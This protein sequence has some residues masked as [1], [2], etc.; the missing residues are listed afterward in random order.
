MAHCER[1]LR[2]PRALLSSR[3][4]LKAALEYSQLSVTATT[5]MR[6]K[7]ASFSPFHRPRGCEGLSHRGSCPAGAQFLFDD[8]LSKLAQLF[9]HT[10]LEVLVSV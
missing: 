10:L 5:S 3:K 6:G 1:P 9:S 7:G 8:P 2:R 4:S